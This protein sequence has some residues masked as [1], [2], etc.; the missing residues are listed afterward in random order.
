MYLTIKHIHVATVILS[1]ALFFI[2]GLWMI[3]DS[4]QLQRRWVRIAPHVNDTILL[5]SAIAMTTLIH[6]YPFVDHWLTAKV[7][8]LALYIGL[9]TIALRRGRTKKVRIAAWVGALMVF[10]Y[11]VSVAMSRQPLPFSP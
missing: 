1:V 5:G 11:I 9:G 8:A 4:P 2:R 3:A 10:G 7:L 6:Q